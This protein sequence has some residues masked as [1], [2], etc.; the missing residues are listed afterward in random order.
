MPRH[1][2]TLIAVCPLLLLAAC[3][4]GNET[5]APA[6]EATPT[7]TVAAATPAAATPI[8]Y[9]CLPAQR[10]TATYDNSGETP[11]ATLALEGTIYELFQVTSASGAKYAT[12]EGRTPGKTLVWFTKDTDGTLYEGTVGGTE[13][14]ETKLAECSPSDAAG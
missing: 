5:A 14:D 13:A 2:H 6:E 8:A 12:D 1:A 9:D 10:L 4:G 7:P 3:G 11:K